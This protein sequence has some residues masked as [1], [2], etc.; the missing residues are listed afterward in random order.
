MSCT[1][2]TGGEVCQKQNAGRIGRPAPTKEE[3]MAAIHH[4]L[5]PL[6][7]VAVTIR[8]KIVIVIRRKR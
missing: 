3:M 5:L 1:V 6:M 7:V 4:L 2:Q 8:V